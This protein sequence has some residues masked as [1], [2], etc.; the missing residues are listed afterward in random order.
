MSWKTKIVI[1][2]VAVGI[3]AVAVPHYTG[4]FGNPLYDMIVPMLP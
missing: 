4:M 1:V 2:V 3:L